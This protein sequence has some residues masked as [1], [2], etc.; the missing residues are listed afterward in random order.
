VCSAEF[1]GFRGKKRIPENE[2]R[3]EPEYKTECTSKLPNTTSHGRMG[4][5]VVLVGYCCCM[6]P[7]RRLGGTNT[8]VAM[9]WDGNGDGGHG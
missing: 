3:Q 1:R 8:K 6:M 7:L 4:H 2:A 9:A 5:P